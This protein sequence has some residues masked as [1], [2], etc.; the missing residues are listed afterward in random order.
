MYRTVAIVLAEILRMLAVFGPF[1]QIYCIILECLYNVKLDCDAR[2]GFVVAPRCV[3]IG[4][5]WD[6]PRYECEP[7]P[8]S[9]HF[10]AQQWCFLTHPDF[11]LCMLILVLF[12]VPFTFCLVLYIS[13]DDWAPWRWYV[14]LYRPLHDAVLNFILTPDF[15]VLV[16]S[17]LF[18]I[19]TWL[20]GIGIFQY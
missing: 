5:Y 8:F 3:R 16:L 17:F 12:L 1:L 18:M 10:S 19:L 11:V 15:A 9:S 14:N 2:P 6:P 7:K 20:L 4:Y 13:K